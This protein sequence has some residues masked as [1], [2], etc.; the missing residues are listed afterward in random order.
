LHEQGGGEVVALRG[1]GRR[2][3]R[4]SKTSCP[5]GRLSRPSSSKKN[6]GKQTAADGLDRTGSATPQCWSVVLEVAHGTIA[7]ILWM[8]RVRRTLEMEVADRWRPQ[9]LCR[10]TSCCGRTLADQ[11]E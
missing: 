7:R 10:A 2:L 1:N 3:R 5:I 8:G 9:L 4:S 6:D 11:L